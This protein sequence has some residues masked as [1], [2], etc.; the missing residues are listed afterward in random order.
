[1]RTNS[2]VADDIFSAIKE[3]S[4]GKRVPNFIVGSNKLKEVSEKYR[5]K[6]NTLL[7][8]ACIKTRR[9]LFFLFFCVSLFGQDFTRLDYYKNLASQGVLTTDEAK[10]LVLSNT[11]LDS[12][13]LSLADEIVQDIMPRSSIR[14]KAFNIKS[15]ILDVVKW[16]GDRLLG[17]GGMSTKECID[18]VQEIID[19]RC[20]AETE[21]LDYLIDEK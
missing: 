17:G 9:T 6:P 1:M 15:F 19:L 7:K 12:T 21:S 16:V 8:I 2:Q 14:S 4:D 13:S 5:I 11:S 18:M 20:R 3:L 10:I